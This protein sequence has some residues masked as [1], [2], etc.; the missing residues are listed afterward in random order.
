MLYSLNNLAPLHFTMHHYIA[1]FHNVINKNAPMKNLSR[2]EKHFRQKPWI[3]SAIKKS[4][5]TKNKLYRLKLKNP[6]NATF[7]RDYKIY[8]NKLTRVK[9]QAKRL[10]YNQLI[11]ENMHNFQKVW[12]T[13]NEILNKVPKRNN[14]RIHQI[15]DNK[16]V[17]H[18]DPPAISNTFNNY[19][20]EVG[21]SMAKDIPPAKSNYINNIT[22]I[23]N[24]LFLLKPNY[25][26]R[27]TLSYKKLKQ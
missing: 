22:S 3:T 26:R 12:K 10:Y 27:N 7:A 15:L 9:E 19:F 14:L 4:I 1:P 16:G 17:I 24:I 11:Q 8:R 5:K 23:Y 20:A 6:N 2:K 18:T 21:P 25:R 13:I